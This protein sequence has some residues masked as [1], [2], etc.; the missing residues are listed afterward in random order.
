MLFLFFLND[1][2]NQKTHI[3][4]TQITSFQTILQ[5]TFKG[6]NVYFYPVFKKNL[7]SKKKSKNSKLKIIKSMTLIY[8]K[9]LFY[10]LINKPIQASVVRYLFISLIEEFLLARICS[11]FCLYL[12]G[13]QDRPT[14]NQYRTRNNSL[15]GLAN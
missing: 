7:K 10:Y 3:S 12:S 5:A 1:L 15:T 4:K 14:P 9:S 13:L 2:T 11:T 6:T 8:Q